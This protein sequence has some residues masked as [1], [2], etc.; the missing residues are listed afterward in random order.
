MGGGPLDQTVGQAEARSPEGLGAGHAASVGFVVHVEKVEDTVEH[1]N[2]E[3][4][5]KR[6]TEL[7]ALGAGARQGDGEIA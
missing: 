5:F 1:E 3:L 7:R 6:V 4:G 2:A